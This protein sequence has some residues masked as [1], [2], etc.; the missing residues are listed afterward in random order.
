MIGLILLC[1]PWRPATS[2]GTTPALPIDRR[3]LHRRAPVP[4]R[5]ESLRLHHRRP[6]HRQPARCRRRRHRPHRRA[7]LPRRA[8]PGRRPRSPAAAGQHP[9]HRRADQRAAGADRRRP[10]QVAQAQ[11]ALVFA[12]QQAARYQDLAQERRGQRAE[13]AA[14]RRRSCASSRRRWP[15]RKRPAGRAAAGRRAE[16]AARERRRQP[17]AGEG[18]AR[19]GQAQP[20]LHH[21]PRRAAGR[22]VN[23]TAPVGQFAQPGTS[24][25]MFVPDEIWVTANFKETQLDAMRPGSR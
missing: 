8:R 5:A 1:S 13:C 11:A 24:L 22:V 14:V 25:T 19:P 18:A 16:G 6:R 17:R 23:L 15:P 2:T 21:R 7:R 3:R 20:L 10:G 12:Q 9:Q 4:H